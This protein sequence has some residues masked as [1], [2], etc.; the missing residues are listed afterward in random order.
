MQTLLR[1]IDWSDSEIIFT[2]CLWKLLQNVISLENKMHYFFV[3]N[4]KYEWINWNIE[5]NLQIVPAAVA[6]VLE[7]R[8]VPLMIA[9]SMSCRFLSS[10]SPSACCLEQENKLKNEREEKTKQKLSKQKLF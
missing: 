9:N 5:A 4:N 10:S 2:V 8:Y 6:L 7:S 1:A 3:I